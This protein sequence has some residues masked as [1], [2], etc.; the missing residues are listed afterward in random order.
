MDNIFWKHS[1]L[2]IY[3]ATVPDRLHHCDLGLFNY[4]VCFTH[5]LI[6]KFCGQK[7]IDEFNYRLTEIPRFPELKLFKN[8]L[9][10]IA[11]FT[12]AEFRHMMKQLVFVIDGLILATHKP[13]IEKNEATKQDKQLVDLFVTWNKMYL[14]SRQ[15]TFSHSELNKFQVLHILFIYLN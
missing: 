8:G 11:R 9:G 14:F 1:Q 6:K 15:E 2:N 10:N 3:N 12:A 13:N 7:G 5:E 4:Q